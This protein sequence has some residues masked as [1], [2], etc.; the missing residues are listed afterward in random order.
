MVFFE[1]VWAIIFER[2]K[3]KAGVLKMPFIKQIT[4]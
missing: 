1:V 4:Y 2:V 3:I